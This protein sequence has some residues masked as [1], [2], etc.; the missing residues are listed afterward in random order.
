LVLRLFLYGDVF[1]L[2]DQKRPA[3]MNHACEPGNEPALFGGRVARIFHG[4]A[5]VLALHHLVNTLKHFRYERIASTSERILANGQIVLTEVGVAV[6]AVVA[7]ESLPFPIY[8]DDPAVRIEY[9]NLGGKCVENV[10]RESGG[11]L[12]T[13]GAAGRR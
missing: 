3:L 13:P 12:V 9:C 5:F 11:H 10:V 6:A 1:M 4:Q 2:R 8:R 7:R